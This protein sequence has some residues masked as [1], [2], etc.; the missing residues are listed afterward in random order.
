MANPASPAAPAARRPV[1]RVTLYTFGAFGGI[2]FGYDLGVIAGV[3]VLLAKQ[4]SLTAFQKGAITA[5]LSVGAMVGAML[6]GRLSNRAGRRLTIM[7]AAVVV[8]IGTVACVLA[9]GWQVMML[10][11]GVI[12]I[13]IGLSSATVPAYLAELAPARVRGALGSLNQLFIVTGILI[14]FLVD[15]ALSSHNNWKGMFLGALVPAVILLAGLTILP[16]T[17]RWLL[18]KGR[19][20]EARAVL[21]ATLPSA[22][23]AELDAEVQDIRDVIRRDSEE[24]GRIR[25]L[26]QPWVRPMVLVA[27][28][29]AIGQQFSGVNAINAYFPTMLKSLGFATRTALLSAVVLGVVKFL[30]TVWELFMVDRWGR[31]PLLMI[32]ASVMV[33]SLFAAGLVI[34]NVTDKDTLGT[35]TL[36]FLILYLAGYE[37]GWGATVWVMIGE[38]FPLRARAA[39]TAVATTVLWAATGLVTAVFPTMSAKSNL[40]IGG[41]MWVFAGVNIVL[42]L[43]ARFYIPETKGR[44]LEQIERDLRG[45]KM[46]ASGAEQTAGAT[47]V[48]A[49]AAPAGT[50]TAAGSATEESGEAGLVSES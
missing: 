41:A 26:W 38:I 4:W 27:L 8:I 19:D 45:G 40:G 28:I 49:Q 30:F 23:A 32:G 22:T 15:Y 20:A 33:V 25:D 10:T 12:G 1:N 16:E 14:A 47:T 35:L 37:L 9:G 31:R 39:G 48:P 17:P 5:S 29:L 21:S 44:S 13:G 7:A 46:S 43:L 24:R 36:V 11:R 3:L 50:G 18:S 42:L 2:L 34:K 6:A